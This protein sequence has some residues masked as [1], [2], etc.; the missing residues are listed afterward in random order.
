[1]CPHAADVDDGAA[2]P[3]GDHAHND[4]MRQ[5]EQGI[6]EFR[7]RVVELLVVVKKRRREKESGC[8]DQQYLRVNGDGYT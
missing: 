3:A 7:V 6:V 2:L 8:A 1:M 4:V 5:E